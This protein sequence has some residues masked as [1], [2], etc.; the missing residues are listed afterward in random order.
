V[1]DDLILPLGAGE[2]PKPSSR[3][4]PAPQEPLIILKS[5]WVYQ[6]GYRDASM[7]SWRGR[8]RRFRE[9]DLFECSRRSAWFFRKSALFDSLTRS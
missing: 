7:G 5:L 6:A 3:V 1:L 2:H 8:S 9:Q 4:S